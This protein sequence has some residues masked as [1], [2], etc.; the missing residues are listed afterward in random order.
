MGREGV[1]AWLTFVCLCGISSWEAPPTVAMAAQVS[2]II[3]MPEICSPAVSPAVVYL[4]PA[5]TDGKAIRVTT[6]DRKSEALRPSAGAAATESSNGQRTTDNGQRTRKT[7]VVLV[8]QRGLQFTPR[9]Q[10]IALGQTVRFTNLD[11]ETHNV[12][13]VTP[14]FEFNQVAGPGQLLEFRPDRPGVMRLACD[15]HLHMRGFVVVSPTPWVRVCGPDGRF[16]I[17]DVPDGRY[18]LTA[19][20]ETGPPLE[21]PIEVVGGKPLE[22]ATILLP[23]PSEPSRSDQTRR[24]QPLQVPVRPWGDVLDRIS[25][26]LAAS[27]D[28]ALQPDG[29]ARA[30]RLAEDAY[31]VEFEGSDLETAVR[32]YLGFARCGELE[33]QFRAICTAVREVAEKR[34]PPSHLDTLSNKLLLDLISVVQALNAKGITDRARMDAP[35]LAVNRDVGGAA[36]VGEADGAG[37]PAEASALL[38]ALKLGFARVESEAEHAGPDAAASELTTVYMTEFEP[39]ERRLFAYSP[40]DIRALEIRF[41]SLRGELSS[42]LKGQELATQVD[43]LVSDV[44]ALLA[45]VE[46]RPAGT[47]GA[48]FV[49]SLITIVREGLEVILVLAMLV[50]L[51]SKAFMPASA[52]PAAH[53]GNGRSSSPHPLDASISEVNSMIQAK[54]RALRAIWWGT[55]LAAVASVATAIALSVLVASVQGGAREILEGVVMLVAACVLFYVSHWLISHVE[56]KR[57]MD[58]LK[59]QARRGLELGGRGALGL[60]AFLAVYREGAETA[61]LYQA[62]LGSEGRSHAGLLGV[63]IGLVAGLGLLAVIAVFIRVTTVRLPV[64]AFFKLSGLFLF[65]LSVVFAGNGVFELQN[66]GVLRTTNLGWM[67]RGLPSLGLYPNVQVVSVQS[68]LLAGAV[69]AW[70]LIPREAASGRARGAAAADSTRSSHHDSAA[71]QPS[72]AGPNPVRCASPAPSQTAGVGV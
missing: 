4:T 47:F 58:F 59:E 67:G 19:W 23:G 39:M 21:T 18:I 72:G 48:A 29:L 28:A 36:P 26:A 43:S 15:I 31:W 46:A 50:A 22:L 6:L 27:G 62:L 41:N 71:A 35:E 11:N 9:V 55:G 30:R 54:G 66:A 63:V 37:T 61:L 1:R 12:H 45:K 65:G 10:A 70:L 8:N 3:K 33:R 42:G 68:L 17:D 52:P 7:N 24:G 34:Q 38:V 5:G 60:T 64:R 14:G 69:L 25:Q 32:R 16:R 44:E 51:V 20:H 49:A 56:A 53:K 40:Q 2:G 13:I 57:W